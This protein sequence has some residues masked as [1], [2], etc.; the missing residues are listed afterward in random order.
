MMTSKMFQG[1]SSGLSLFLRLSLSVWNR[2]PDAD[3]DQSLRW[4]IL[5]LG[6]WDKSRLQLASRGDDGC[7]GMWCEVG[8]RYRDDGCRENRMEDI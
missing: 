8:I 3:S 7:D 4:A 5:K 2:N 6:M 1:L